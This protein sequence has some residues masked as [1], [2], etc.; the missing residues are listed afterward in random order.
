[1]L[2]KASLL[3][4]EIFSFLM[5]VKAIKNMDMRTATKEEFM[6][7]SEMQLEGA[8]DHGELFN[9]NRGILVKYKG[10]LLTNQQKQNALNKLKDLFDE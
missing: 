2:K 8:I 5:K 10:R 9:F 1:M 6:V 7:I 4:D 3:S